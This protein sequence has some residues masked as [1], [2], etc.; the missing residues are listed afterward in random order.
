[1]KPFLKLTL[2]LFFFGLTPEQKTNVCEIEEN[3][4]L[5]QNEL[6]VLENSEMYHLMN[7]HRIEY[8]VLENTELFPVE[9]EIKD[10]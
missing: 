1:M 2:V 3:C 8:S 10:K 9:K 6:L 7:F 4:Q 5:G